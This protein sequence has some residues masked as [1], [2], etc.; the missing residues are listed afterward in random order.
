MNYKIFIAIFTTFITSAM[1]HNAIISTS[2]P[3]SSGEISLLPDKDTVLFSNGIK[4]F[5]MQF[6]APANVPEYKTYY[7]AISFQWSSGKSVYKFNSALTTQGGKESNFGPLQIGAAYFRYAQDNID[8]NW[9]L[10]NHV[11]FV[12]FPSDSIFKL[13]SAPNLSGYNGKILFS[14][15]RENDQDIG[16]NCINTTQFIEHNSIVYFI[17]EITGKSAMKIQVDSFELDTTKIRRIYGGYCPLSIIAQIHIRWAI[18]SLGNG[19][20]KSMTSI[21]KPPQSPQSPIIK[22]KS[23]FLR[24]NNANSNPSL[25]Y[26]ELFDAQGKPFSQPLSKGVY[27]RP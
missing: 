7:G 20:F 16:G 18:D 15:H 24:I 2:L 10:A 12:T 27:F 23:N 8:T 9:D 5:S 3:Y 11:P 13:E 26:D 25:N 19:S 22:K 1:A 14:Y 17:P 21:Q 4:I 6:I